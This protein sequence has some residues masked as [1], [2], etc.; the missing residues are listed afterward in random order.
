MAG[1]VTD[2]E[3]G[4][5]H[6]RLVNSMN[7]ALEASDTAQDL[8][9][10]YPELPAA[11]LSFLEKHAMANPALLT[12]IARFLKD[13]SITCAVEDSEEESELQTR[14]NK[15]RKVTNVANVSYIDD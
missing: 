6:R 15:K 10:G 14:L 11:V 5:L 1:N 7:S 3:L 13:N 12:S 4:K 9:D 2:L 8:L